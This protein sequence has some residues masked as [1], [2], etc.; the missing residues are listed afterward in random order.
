ML[1]KSKW[2]VRTI[3]VLEE[4]FE[5]RSRQ[6]DRYGHNDDLAD[7]SGPE[8]RWLLPYTSDSAQAV[9]SALRADYEGFED[10]TGKPTW[11]HLLRE[12]LAEVFAEDDSDRLQEE[13]VQVA[14]LAVSWVESLR[15]RED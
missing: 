7:G 9:E 1:A 14:A 11:V 3:Q 2:Q 6:V 10:E 15:G 12:E 4:V 5:E 8:T 13:L